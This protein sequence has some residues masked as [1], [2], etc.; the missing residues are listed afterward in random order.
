VS[1]KNIGIPF[2]FNQFEIQNATIQNLLNDPGSPVNGQIWVNTTSWTLKI[3][4]NGVTIQ[5]GRLDQLTAPTA[6]VALNGQ[7]ITGMADPVSAQDAATQQW[8]N[9]LVAAQISGQDWKAAVRLATTTALPSNTYSTGALTLT[10]TANGALTL[11]GVGVATNDRVMV[12]NE[13]TGS[14]NGLYVVTNTGSAGA[15]YV[16]TR[17]SDANVTSEISNGMTVPV[18]SGSTQ[19][20]TLWVQTAD[21]PVLDTTALAFNQIGGSGATY[22]AGTGL[23]LTGNQF[24]LTV[25]VAVTNGGTGATTQ[26]GARAALGIVSKY[27][28]QGPSSGSTTWSVVHNLGSTEVVYM[29]RDASTSAEIIADVVVTDANTLTITFG[30]SVATNAYKI[31][32]IG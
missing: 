24:A 2:N 4:L 6:S 1:A 12:K 15:P 25:P 31:V 19:A 18:L 11:D 29:L 21:T 20:D 28:A 17:A 14:H 23:T 30:A 3:R 13:P 26:A 8:V 22:T 10:A 16:L 9:N 7:R 27:N 32:V 5:L